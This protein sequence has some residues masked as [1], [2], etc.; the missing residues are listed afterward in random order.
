MINFKSKQPRVLGIL[1]FSI[2]F[3]YKVTGQSNLLIN[4][5]SLKIKKDTLKLLHLEEVLINTVRADRNLPVTETSI[6]KSDI[7][8]N[9]T[10][11]EMPV[12]LA[13]TPSVTWY[14]DG[15]NYTGYSY[16][17]L[18]GLDQTRVN[19]TLNGVPLNEPEDQGAYFSNYPD[20]LNS[21]HSIQVQ[22]GVGISTNGTAAFAGSINMESPHLNDSSYTELSSSYGS[23]NTYRVSPE[24]NTGL[25]KNNWSFYGRYS[26]INSDGFKE[27]SGTK[28]QSFFFSGGYVGTKGI[29]KFTSFTGVAK[30]QMAYLAVSDSVL[31]NN[32]R[33]NN[34]TQDEKDEFKQTLAMVQYIAPIG[35]KSTITST[36]F[37]NYLEGGYSIL[38][39]PDLYNYLVKSNFYGGIVNY[40]Y[41]RNA[42]KVNAGIHGNT[43]NRQHYSSVLPNESKLLYKNNGIKNEFSSF[44]KLSYQIKQ[45]MFFGDLQYRYAEFTYQSDKNSPLNIA[46]ANWQ[47]INPKAGISYLIKSKH[48]LYASIGRSSREPTRN[49]MFA[50]YDNIDSLNYKE[51]GNLSRIKPETVTDLEL[52]IKLLYQKC[53]LELNVYDMEFKNEIAAIGQLSYIG[54]PLR[55]NVA[56]SFRRGMELNLSATPIKHLSIVTQANWSFNRI[57]TYTT[58]YDSL[59]YKNVQPLLTPNLVINQSLGYSFSKWLKTEISARYMS[60]SYLDNSNN[61]KYITPSSL[62]FN[63]AICVSFL[64]QHSINFMVNNITDQKYYTSG[65]V[66]SGQPYYFAMATRNYFVTLKLRF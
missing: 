63:A 23:Y 39:T 47:F 22:R 32:Y 29:F 7:E 30:N 28:G 44:L 56:S 66:Q 51:I 54:L 13:K 10:G 25:L 36:L 4:T 60:Q 52:G 65:Y 12:I 14:S 35:Q 53:K 11:Q 40:Q 16:L 59:T 42:F 1:I 19:F 64:R 27:H 62:T 41:Q 6:K 24:F 26:N 5:D 58:D 3:N 38:F 18:R 43:Y 33:A 50:G 20:F 49:D 9:Y 55:K 61:D 8:H 31:K 34:L 17:R 2:I 37:Y 46:P 57:K 15:G 48:V 45:L 21:I